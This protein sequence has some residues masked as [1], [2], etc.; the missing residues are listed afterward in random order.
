MPATPSQERVLELTDA[1]APATGRDSKCL[2]SPL[3]TEVSQIA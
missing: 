1:D 3:K 2:F